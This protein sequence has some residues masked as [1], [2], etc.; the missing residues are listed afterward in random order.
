MDHGAGTI[1][2]TQGRKLIRDEHGSWRQGG[3]TKIYE[4]GQV[5]TKAPHST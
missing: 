4:K 1:V 3:E 5:T 2:E